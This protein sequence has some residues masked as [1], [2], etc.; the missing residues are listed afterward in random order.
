MKALLYWGGVAILGLLLGLGSVVPGLM[1]GNPATTLNSGPWVTTLAAGSTDADMY[2]R[3]RVALFGLLALSK[4]ETMY[5]RASSDSAGERLSGD[6]TYVVEGADLAAHWWAITAY[7]LDGFLI[8]N[9]AGIYSFARTTVER[10]A[11]GR[12]VVR[13]SAERQEGNWLPVKAGDDFDLTARLYNPEA[14]VYSAPQEAELPS[15]VKESCR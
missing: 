6:C 11:D 12:Y 15:I 4:E 5:Y 3:A 13:L 9:D 8:P 1:L 10:G 2:T 14:S 7:R